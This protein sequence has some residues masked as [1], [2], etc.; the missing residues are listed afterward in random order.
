MVARRTWQNT[1]FLRCVVVTNR[2]H[3]PRPGFCLVATAG[4]V[5]RGKGSDQTRRRTSRQTVSGP[6]W[7][8][9]EETQ[10]LC[11]DEKVSADRGANDIRH[12]DDHR[13][14][15]DTGGDIPLLNPVSNMD[16]ME[17]IE[18]ERRDEEQNNPDCCPDNRQARIDQELFHVPPPQ[19]H[20][21]GLC[22]PHRH[23]PP[24]GPIL[25]IIRPT[26][27]RPALFLAIRGDRASNERCHTARR[28]TFRRR[29]ARPGSAS[30]RRG[31]SAPR[32]PRSGARQ[33]R[34]AAGRSDDAAG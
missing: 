34:R 12:T 33:S 22:S 16:R 28:L 21:T 1:P 30:Y 8:A 18:D 6:E 29:R 19:I 25:G 7:P 10:S 31:R 23:Q 13:P 3:A 14:E 24:A 20:D 5:P 15:Q 27:N 32:N 17:E 9:Q 26:C 2:D 4:S 11:G